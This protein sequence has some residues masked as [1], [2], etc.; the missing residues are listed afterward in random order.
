MIRQLNYKMFRTLNKAQPIT[1]DE[2]YIGSQ[3]TYFDGNFQTVFRQY[4][5]IQFVR[6]FVFPDYEVYTAS[7]VTKARL[8]SD[9]QG[10]FAFQPGLQRLKMTALGTRQY[11]HVGTRKLIR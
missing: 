6:P 10:G 9:Q 2:L 1:R 8:F 4:S 3:L 7:F 11:Y 5:L